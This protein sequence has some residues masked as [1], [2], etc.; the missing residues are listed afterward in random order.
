MNIK[1]VLIITVLIVAFVTVA[2]F[3]PLIDIEN[4]KYEAKIIFDERS[5]IITSGYY[6]WKV[7]NATKGDSVQVDFSGAY[8]SSTYLFTENQYLNFKN[9]GDD[10]ALDYLKRTSQGRLKYNFTTTGK[11]YFVFGNV[12][13]YRVVADF[14]GTITQTIISTQK[15][16]VLQYLLSR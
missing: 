10:M 15:V 9:S 4:K 2:S 1:G 14:K 11:Y 13:T 16:T 7:F 8:D 12:G 5:F 6:T 3:V